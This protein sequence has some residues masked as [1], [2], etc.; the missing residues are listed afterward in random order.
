MSAHPHDG[1]PEF[2]QVEQRWEQALRAITT[3][4]EVI[5]SIYPS[6]MF[7]LPEAGHR[8]LKDALDGAQNSVSSLHRAGRYVLGQEQYDQFVTDQAMMSMDDLIASSA[9]VELT[10]EQRRQVRDLLESFLSEPES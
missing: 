5:R 7:L 2:L 3:G 6:R 10:D 9:D 4:M 8:A 1:T